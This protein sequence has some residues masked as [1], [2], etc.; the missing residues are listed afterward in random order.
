MWGLCEPRIYKLSI[1]RKIS[2][3]FDNMYADHFV[4]IDVSN[5][6][7]RELLN[8]HFRNVLKVFLLWRFRYRW[9][10]LYNLPTPNIWIGIILNRVEKVQHRSEFKNNLSFEFKIVSKLSTLNFTLSTHN[11]SVYRK[12]FS[13]TPKTLFYYFMHRECLKKHYFKI[14]IINEQL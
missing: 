13:F 8:T 9:Y 2:S 12:H 5:V 6:R 1:I 10:L 14:I 4:R 11:I 7:T 3:V